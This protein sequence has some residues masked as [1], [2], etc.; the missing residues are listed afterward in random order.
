MSKSNMF[1]Q[2]QKPK[3]A[4]AMPSLSLK[5][6]ISLALDQGLM[7]LQQHPNLFHNVGRYQLGHAD[8]RS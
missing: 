1:P 8:L 5:S 6:V 4:V 2:K 3:G 7:F